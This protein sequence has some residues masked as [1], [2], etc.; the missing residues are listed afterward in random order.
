VCFVDAVGYNIQEEVM[1]KILLFLLVV[2]PAYVT[3]SLYFMD[4]GYFIC[5]IEYRGE[6]I[7]RS[8]TRG[9]GFFAARR[10]GHRTHEGVDLFAEIGTPVKAARSGRVILS[11]RIVNLNKKT[12][13]GNYIIILHP[14]NV[15]TTYGHL[16]RV[17]VNQNNFVRQGQVIGWVGKTGNANYPDIQPHLHFEIRKD[18]VPQDPSEYLE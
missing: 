18:G 12:G 17:C 14:G 10:N 13:S 11:R 5:P 4:T 3:L 1:K 7:I 8:D 16:L 9:D 2:M 6:T 15:T